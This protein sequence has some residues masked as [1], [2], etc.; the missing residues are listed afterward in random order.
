[1]KDAGSPG[2]RGVKLVGAPRRDCRSHEFAV[3]TRAFD[4]AP[5]AYARAWVRRDEQA[6][7]RFPSN[8]LPRADS[9]GSGDAAGGRSRRANAITGQ[10]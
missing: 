9:S 5:V 1:M 4:Q 3:A 7:R 10:G 2:R 6:S 8:C